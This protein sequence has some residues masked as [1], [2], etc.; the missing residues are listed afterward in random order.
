MALHYRNDTSWPEQQLL[1]G[2]FESSQV[3]RNLELSTHTATYMYIYREAYFNSRLQYS[4]IWSTCVIAQQY[5]STTFV[6]L[7]FRS[8]KKI[9]GA[10][11]IFFFFYFIQ[12]SFSLRLRELKLLKSEH[13]WSCFFFIVRGDNGGL[14]QRRKW[15][16]KF[17]E[18][19]VI[20]WLA[21]ILL[22]CQE[23]LWNMDLF[24]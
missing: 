14:L 4:R 18:L 8:R 9:F 2:R 7:R 10:F 16:L 20:L 12:I 15:A 21:E 17:N 1:S 13:I 19:W 23:G 24:N 11:Q 6:S 3:L 22:A 5:S